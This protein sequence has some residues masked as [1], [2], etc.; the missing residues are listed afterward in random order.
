MIIARAPLRI[1]LAGGGTDLPAYADRFGGQVIST[2]INRYVYI[3]LSEAPAEALQITAADSHTVLCRREHLFDSALHWNGDHRLPLE[4]LAYLGIGGGCRLFIAA[5][6]PPGTGL[7][8][9]STTAVALIT[10]LTSWQGRTLTRAEVAELA[11]YLEIERM[12]MPI[13]RQDQYAAAFGGLNT[14]SFQHGETEVTPLAVTER[15]YLGLQERL[16]LFFTG[17]RRRSSDVL[18]AQGEAIRQANSPALAALH[19]IK[20]LAREM[21]YALET[22]DLAAVGRLLD[23]SW[24]R[25]RRLSAGVTNERIDGWYSAAREAGAAG[26]KI[27]GAGGGGFLMLYVEPEHRRAVIHRMNELGLVWVDAEFERT[28]AT[29]VLT[30]PPLVPVG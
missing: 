22:G 12:G 13:G 30:A 27:T 8:S 29:A 17:Q 10:A 3:V 9:S 20:A 18:K 6:V 23:E 1:S 26:G 15:T 16:L 4:T 21:K 5:E 2:T 28:G 19:E 25:K 14:I 7:G 24:Q 11:C